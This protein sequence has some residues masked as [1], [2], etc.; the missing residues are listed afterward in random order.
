MTL[1]PI[2]LVCLLAG[3]VLPRIE[4]VFTAG[5]QGISAPLLA[6]HKLDTYTVTGRE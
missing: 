2:G 4:G 1:L 3:V 6:V 5:P